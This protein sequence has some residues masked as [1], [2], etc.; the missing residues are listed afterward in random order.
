MKKRFNVFMDEDLHSQIKI[1]ATLSKKSM[2][3]YI[4]EAIK[5][6]IEKEGK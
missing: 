3:E 4:L 5:E 1:S 6:K 2:N